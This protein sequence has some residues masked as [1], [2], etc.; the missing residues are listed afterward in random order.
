MKP[1]Y[2]VLFPET[3]S[4]RLVKKTKRFNPFFMM[5]VLLLA[6]VTSKSQQNIFVDATSVQFP[7]LP[8]LSN[9]SA[10]WADYDGDG[11]QDVLITG[12]DQNNNPVSKLFH[13]TKTGFV[14]VSRL[15][16]GL[17][18]VSQGSVAWGDYNKDGKTNFFICG[19]PGGQ[20]LSTL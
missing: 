8:Q 15:V 20:N 10:A 12:M 9:S 6:A 1:S 14:D 5:M 17:P 4:K 13:N 7:G 2:S 3:R 18:Q 16:P 19:N 11:R